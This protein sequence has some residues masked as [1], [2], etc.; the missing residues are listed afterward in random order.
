M[1][2]EQENADKKRLRFT[3][4]TSDVDLTCVGYFSDD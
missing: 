3:A 1:K 2:V 4:S